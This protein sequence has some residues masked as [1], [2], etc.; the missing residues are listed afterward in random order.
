[1]TVMRVRGAPPARPASSRSGT[2][3]PKA[4][5]I[6]SG[7]GGAAGPRCSPAGSG[8][9]RARRVP[10]LRRQRCA[11][12][13]RRRPAAA[14]GAAAFEPDL[15]SVVVGVNDTLRC[16]FDIQALARRLDDGLRTAHGRAGTVLLTACLPDPGGMLGLPVP[17]ARPLARR[18]RAVNAVVHALSARYD[19]VHLHAADAAWVADRAMW[20]ADRLHPGER[21][22][23][24]I[25]RRF[26]ALLV[27]RGL[28]HGTAPGREPE[29]PAP[30]RSASLLWLATAGT[31]WVARRCTDLL[32]QLLQSGRR[33]GAPPGAR[34]QRPARP[35][36]RTR[37]FGRARC[38][39]PG[40]FPCQNGG[41]SGRWEFWIDRG[42]TFTDVVGQAPRRTAGDPQTALAR[43]RAVPGRGRRRDPAAARRRPGRARSRPTGSPASRWAPPSP[44]TPCWSAGRA[45][46]PRHHRRAS[47]TPCASPTRTGPRLFDRRILLPE[48]LYDRVI[49]VP[50]RVDAH[51]DVV[52]A[53]RP[54]RRSREQLKAA[55]RDG[56][57]S[58]AVVL[59]HGY[60][61][62]AHER[63][64]PNSP[65]E[66]GFTQ[67]SCSHEV[68]PL[69]KLVPRGDTTVV[70]A[71]LSPD[72]AALRRRG[73]RRTRAASG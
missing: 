59:L 32:P 29:Q 68:S 38:G 36:R 27:E 70:D 60:R 19:A 50:E 61:H 54:G 15:A 28:A 10:Q 25:A 67:V 39:V 23:R 41:M 21:G 7:T 9:R 63:R 30:T 69:I 22:H 40:R 47:G 64:S 4:S 46:R 17:L 45:D 57:R 1:M 13:G 33:R 53:A 42:G 49:E 18:Q 11:H 16:T 37:A 14:R 6:P 26:H 8:R 31:G 35:Q 56:F 3:S 51:G 72:P 2:R 55:R 48:A 58:A 34:H 65:R 73:R 12:R 71:Y 43:P 52:R 20:S 24:M 62:P 66:L 44:P 5:A